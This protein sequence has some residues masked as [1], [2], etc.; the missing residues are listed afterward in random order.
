MNEQG[1]HEQARA[2]GSERPASRWF[3]AVAIAFGCNGPLVGVTP[4]P[5]G[6]AAG[7]A[8]HPAVA[9]QV[10]PGGNTATGGGLVATGGRASGGVLS[11]GMP[12]GGAGGS[13]T[14]GS[15]SA[16][17]TGGGATGGNQSGGSGTG[18]AATGG[19]PAGGAGGNGC[20]LQFPALNPFRTGANPP[21]MFQGNLD[22]VFWVEQAADTSYYLHQAAATDPGNSS[23]FAYVVATSG[24][25]FDLRV[26]GD[27]G[28]STNGVVA[29][30]RL[31]ADP[32][33][34]TFDSYQSTGLIKAS[35]L[36]PAVAADA[37]RAYYVVQD[38]GKLWTWIPPYGTPTSILTFS[39]FGIVSASEIELM[40]LSDNRIVLSNGYQV[41]L[42]SPSLNPPTLIH[43]AGTSGLIRGIRATSIDLLLHVEDGSYPTGH[44]YYLDITADA[45]TGPL[46]DLAAAIDPLDPQGCSASAHQYA[47]RGD[48]YSGWYVYQAAG[49]LYRVILTGGKIYGP[50]I[51][52]TDRLLSYP[53]VTRRGGLFAL[54][55]QPATWEYYYVGAL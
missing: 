26:G 32:T 47:G 14:G 50:P 20:T 37:A 53:T 8:G 3:F 38:T 4:T 40:E 23:A 22:R 9:G 19:S 28:G 18:G 42:Y 2:A 6:G 30:L 27:V 24:Q 34:E 29:V 41:W 43:I 1:G 11:G 45:P 7:S 5:N 31:G 55:Q 52:V 12:G 13:A 48:I 10:G 44:D 35:T 17:G 46:I 39:D 15:I 51:P 25:T 33:L 54:R 21:Q 16:G 36:M 49:G